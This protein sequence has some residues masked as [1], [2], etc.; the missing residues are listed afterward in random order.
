MMG[1]AEGGSGFPVQVKDRR[2]D[3]G[4]LAI[5]TQCHAINFME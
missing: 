3:V 2:G 4:K 5:N 1:T